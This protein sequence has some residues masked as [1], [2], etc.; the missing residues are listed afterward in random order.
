[1]V[2]CDDILQY[3]R[4]WIGDRIQITSQGT[5]C[6]LRMP[7][8]DSSGDPIIIVVSDAPDGY[9]VHDGGIIAGHLFSLGQHTENTLAF[10]L[11]TTLCKTYNLTLDRDQGLIKC[12][13]SRDNLPETILELTKIIITI[14][15]ATAHISVQSHRFR[16]L[17]ARVRSKVRDQYAR[18]N[19][20]EWVEPYYEIPG[21][22]VDVW[23][24]DF[25]WKIRQ[26]NTFRDVFITT[27]DLNVA[28]PIRKVEH[29]TALAIDASQIIEANDYRVV[30]DK[31]G[32][33]SM[34]DVAAN[35]LEE[36]GERLG[37]TLYDFGNVHA[38]NRFIAQSELEVLGEAGT[39]W[40]SFWEAAKR[41][42]IDAGRFSR[43]H[44]DEI[45]LTFAKPLSLPPAD[46]ES[47]ET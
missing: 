23:P 43:E 22:T 14:T 8:F 5:S 37:F 34:A 42:Q 29:I 17:G 15:T 45:I 25:H 26:G 16:T 30:L 39:E 36:H 7:F 41:G 19:I 40:R 32:Q 46:Q 3:F 1:M 9:L 35:Y 33:N 38:R 44:F 20:L 24:I 4:D 28:E 2:L 18:R 31:H 12:I 11:L 27:I 6:L 10:K 21:Q 47:G 13:S